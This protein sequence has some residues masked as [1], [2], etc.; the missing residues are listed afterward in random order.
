MEFI[1]K[2]DRL[3][4]T[5][6]SQSGPGGIDASS[7]FSALSLYMDKES[8]QKSIGELFTK[9]YINVINNGG[10]IRYFASKQVRDAMIA[11]E[12]QRYR[13]VSYV[14]ELNKKKDEILQIQDRN[15]QLEEL[16]SVVSKGLTLIALGLINLYSAMPELTIPEFVESIQPLTDVLGKLTRVVEPQYSKEDIENILKIVEKFRGERDYKLLKDLVE[17]TESNEGK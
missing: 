2:R 9:G 13:I 17:K 16:K 10:E 7:L 3:V 4:L 11:L 1:Q 5:L 6:I 14:N 8:I 12:V 15:K